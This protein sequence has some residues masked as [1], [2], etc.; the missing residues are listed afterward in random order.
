M[1]GEA[2]SQSIYER[3]RPG[4]G[5]DY[6]PRADAELS[7][8]LGEDNLRK[9]PPALPEVS[10]SEAVRHYTGLS[11]LNYGVD[12][13]FYPLGSCT[14][15]Y[16]PKIGE[17]AAS[18]PGFA[19]LHPYAREE[20]V[21][22]AL[23]VLRDMEDYLS[24]ICGMDAFSLQPAAGAHGELA[25]L[26]MIAAWHESRGD[27]ARRVMLIPDSAHGTNPASAVMAGFTTRQVASNGQG[28]VD[29]EALRTALGP[30]VAGLMLTNPNTLGL[31]ERDILEIARLTHEAGGLLYYDGANLNAV[32][33]HTSP[34]LMGFDVVHVN[35]HKTFATPHGGGGP[36]SGPV[37]V[38]GSLVPFLPVPRVVLRQGV[39]RLESDRPL[40]I[41][42]VRSFYGNFG[43]ILKAY[44]YILR[45]GPRGLSE[46][47]EAAVLHANYVREKLRGVYDIPYDRTCMHEC[48]LSA[49]R[50]KGRGVS[51]GDRQGADRQGLP[52]AHHVFPADR[53]RGADGG[54][55]LN[56]DARDAVRLH[57]SH[58]VAGRLGRE[59]P[60]RP[61]RG[62]SVHSCGPSRRDAGGAEAGAQIRMTAFTRNGSHIASWGGGMAPC[63]SLPLGSVPRQIRGTGLDRGRVL[64]IRGVA[65]RGRLGAGERASVGRRLVRGDGG[66]R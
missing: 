57:R 40:S 52:P 38:R 13:G 15:K 22:G 28:L 3:S 12:T 45:L 2:V 18:L 62:P 65:L 47:A 19:G 56:G 4:R 30:D 26:M 39:Y 66:L 60:G 29:L 16:N 48:V 31:F 54:A 32:L 1:G 63:H 49:A 58:E 24:D 8:L 51:A 43:V 21:Q 17:A 20:C 64:G 27:A 61:A 25:G 50:Q 37:G 55:N 35:L 46:A 23:R 53:A 6:L 42:R 41:G 44:A 34:G 10:E 14:M 36:G 7:V 11:R 33:G 59:R 9:T 5:T